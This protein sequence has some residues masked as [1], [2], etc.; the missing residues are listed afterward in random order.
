M[1]GISFIVT[2]SSFQNDSYHPARW[3]ASFSDLSTD[4]HFMKFLVHRAEDAEANRQGELVGLSHCSICI[5][6]SAETHAL[7]AFIV[8]YRSM[9]FL[10]STG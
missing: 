7:V 2:C 5:L 10:I 1:Q 6:L 3:L 8:S 9:R 4:A